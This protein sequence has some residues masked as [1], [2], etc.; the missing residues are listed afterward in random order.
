VG[1]VLNIFRN[2]ER[3]LNLSTIN[4]VGKDVLCNVAHKITNGIL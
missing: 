1:E 3:A 2:F 4:K